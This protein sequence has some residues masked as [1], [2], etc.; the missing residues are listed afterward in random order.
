MSL[1]FHA[2]HGVYCTY[3]CF[4]HHP[5]WVLPIAIAPHGD[6]RCGNLHLVA[7]SGADVPAE[8]FANPSKL[9]LYSLS[10]VS[11]S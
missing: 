3:D 1:S 5:V 8:I 2:E 7:T 9:V 4:E 6:V 10:H 11:L